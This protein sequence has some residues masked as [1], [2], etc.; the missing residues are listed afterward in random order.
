MLRE[1][2]DALAAIPC[3]GHCRNLNPKLTFSVVY[4]GGG[5]DRFPPQV[6]RQIGEIELSAE[7]D[8]VIKYSNVMR[9]KQKAEIVSW[10]LDK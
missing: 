6:V 7:E 5:C 2:S 4:G 1:E 9:C 10:P 8:E 3:V